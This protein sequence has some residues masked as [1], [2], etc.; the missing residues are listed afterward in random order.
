MCDICRMNHPFLS[1][2]T[3]EPQ[4]SPKLKHV[5]DTVAR[6]LQRKPHLVSR[7]PLAAFSVIVSPWPSNNPF[8]MPTASPTV[9]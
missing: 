4:V 2:F 3:R 7:T 9:T 8:V 5:T 6:K 1:H